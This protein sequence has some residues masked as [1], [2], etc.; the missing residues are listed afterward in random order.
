MRIMFV[1]ILNMLMFAGCTA[2]QSCQNCGSGFLRLRMFDPV[3]STYVLPI[4]E[5]DTK[6]LFNDS[7]MIMERHRIE[8]DRDK[9]TNQQKWQRIVIGYTFIDFRTQTFY[10]Y[11]HLSDTARIVKAS[12]HP[13]GQKGGGGLFFGE[14]DLPHNS[15]TL[16]DTVLDGTRC[17]RFKSFYTEGNDTVLIKT[18]YFVREEERPVA[19]HAKTVVDGQRFSIVRFDNDN[20]VPRKF[21]DY[22]TMD[23]ISRSLTKK[24]MKVFEAWRQNAIKNPV[25]Q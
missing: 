9:A 14:P 25:P 18:V 13:H 7:M 6:F 17:H 3:R 1:V 20:F 22:S 15:I 4:Y 8:I 23:I 21:K 2:Q 11:R 10:D 19:Y 5:R 24:E 16:P 12:R